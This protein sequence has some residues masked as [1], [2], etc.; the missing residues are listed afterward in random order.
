MKPTIAVT[1]F[2]LAG[3]SQ[4]TFADAAKAAMQD[5]ALI[6]PEAGASEDCK[7]LRVAFRT[8]VNECMTEMKTLSEL[9]SGRATRNTSQSSRARF[10]I[11]DAAVRQKLGLKDQ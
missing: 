4:P 7:A 6:G 10:I 2:L 5:C 9:R 3:F 8:E 11:C 1:F